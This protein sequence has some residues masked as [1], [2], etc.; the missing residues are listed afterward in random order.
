MQHSINNGYTKTI[1]HIDFRSV[2]IF[3]EAQ[4]KQKGTK[5]MRKSKAVIIT[6]FSIWCVTMNISQAANSPGGISEEEIKKIQEAMPVKAV[7]EPAGP[8]KLL[9]FNLCGPGGYRHSSIPYWDKVLE[10]MA[11]KTGAFSV[12]ISNDV[13]VFNA[14]NLKQYDAVCFNNTTTLPFSPKKTPEL[15]KSLMDFVKGGK[16]IV[17]IHAATDSFYKEPFLWPEASQMMGGKFTGH[18]WTGNGTWAIKIDE[19]NHPL[20]APFKGKGFKIKDE[21]YRTE[22]PLYSRSK[23]LVL[24]SLDMADETT[25]KTAEKPTDEDTGISWIKSWG[26]G[27]MFYCS[28]G[29]NHA[30]TWTAPVLEHYLR[31]IQFALGDLKVDTKPKPETK[32]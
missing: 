31:G 18:P 6:L 14:D 9:V 11:Q 5:T 23:Q 12:E 7:V 15:C 2:V 13:N 1:P 4:K 21:I 28:L 20:M 3:Y 8:R 10:I 17:G 32:G 27:R 24:M 22:P 16:G 30:V 29:H 25:Q 26:Q 19:P